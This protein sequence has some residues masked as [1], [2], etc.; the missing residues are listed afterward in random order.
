MLF[1]LRCPRCHNVMK[2]NSMDSNITGKSK[3]CVYCN[4]SFKVKDNVTNALNMPH[5]TGFA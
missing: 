3:Q 4:R 2:Y 5:M 1:S